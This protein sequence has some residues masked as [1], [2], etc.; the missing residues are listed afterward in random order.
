MKIVILTGAGMSVESGLSTF[1]GGGG[2]WDNYPVEA[3]ASAE[4]FRAN[5]A[6]VLEFYNKRRKEL[7]SV[8]P[9]SG[10]RLIAGLEKENDVV[11][12]TQNVDNLHERAGSTNVIHLHGELEKVCSSKNPSDLSCVRKLSPRA[13]EIFMG[14]LAADSSQLRPYIVFFGEEVPLMSTAIEALSGVDVF[15]VIG[16]SLNVY[17]AA[18]LL[19]YVPSSVPVFLIDPNDVPHRG[20]GNV[21]H[22]REGASA[23]MEYFIDKI[24]KRLQN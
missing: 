7:Y 5:P 13:P 21:T 24:L 1:R 17:P 9:N 18:F 15:L 12:I 19:D 16:T 14:D 6:L 10:H 22:I 23:G 2:L 4:G 8:E 3:V 11:V 20:G